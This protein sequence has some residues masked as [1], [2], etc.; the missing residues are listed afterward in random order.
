VQSEFYHALKQLIPSFLAGLAGGVLGAV[1]LNFFLAKPSG[2]PHSE[3]VAVSPPVPARRNAAPPPRP[4]FL[5]S[6]AQFQ[7]VA[8]TSVVHEDDLDSLPESLPPWQREINHLV[9]TLPPQDAVKRLS[10]R[11]PSLPLEAQQE[12]AWRIDSMV[13][14]EDYGVVAELLRN[15]GISQTARAVLFEGLLRRPEEVR[16]PVLANLAVSYHLGDVARAQL[17]AFFGWDDSFSP[18]SW[19]QTVADHLSG[20]KTTGR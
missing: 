2:S 10:A 18:P 5:Q 11:L 3:L 20:A 7:Q 12:A 6:M 4:D 15:P 14:D 8:A 17:R 1:L 13:F 9:D 16:L 19:Q